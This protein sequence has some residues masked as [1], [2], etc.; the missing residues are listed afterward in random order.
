MIDDQKLV[1]E[2]A[3]NLAKKSSELNKN[4]LIVE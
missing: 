2:T 4:V 3:V 1:F